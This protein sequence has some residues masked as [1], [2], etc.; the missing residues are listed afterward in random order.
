[1]MPGKKISIVIPM[2]NAGVFIEKC[3]NSL[4]NQDYKNFEVFIIDD[5][6]KDNS[7]QI[8]KS[9]SNQYDSINYV[10][11]KNGGA[12]N[13]RNV[14]LSLCK[15]DYVIFMDQDDYFISN[16]TF[17]ELIKVFTELPNTDFIIYK[18][19]EYFQKSNTTK[20]RPDFGK[21]AIEPGNSTYDKLHSFV[22][23]GNVP[24]S[25]WD[26][27]FRR[28]FLLNKNILFPVGKIAGDIN[29]FME[30]IEKSDNI[31]VKNSEYYAYRRQVSTSLTNS[32]DINSFINFIEII[33]S[34]S[35]RLKNQLDKK[36]TALFLSFLA[37]EY[38]IL[39]AV[40]SNLNEI[41]FKKYR[42]R[43]NNL[44]WLFQYDT[45]QKVHKVKL[46]IKLI[47]VRKASK[48]LRYYIKKR[49]N[50]K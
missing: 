31:V 7:P 40:S 33:E 17:N 32:F 29:W 11:I 20:K 49:V 34:E 2:Y 13:A 50:R 19:V 9:F 48:F 22:A 15:G 30:L 21:S 36:Y 27:I 44:K 45:N 14:G 42:A 47:G 35:D 37:Y 28:E 18:Y 4:I 25:P 6:S 8:S 10:S 43:I 46:L 41:E 39:L 26:K 24:I 5:G 12:N 16:S 3:L 1:M 38:S 23:N